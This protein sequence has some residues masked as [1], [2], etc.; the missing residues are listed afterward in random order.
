MTEET[1]QQSIGQRLQDARRKKELSRESVAGELNLNVRSIEALEN[2]NFD[3]IS[4]PMFTRGY[5][6]AYAR[7]LGM[8]ADRLI[9]EYN[10]LAPPDPELTSAYQSVKE[11]ES[12]HPIIRWA[13]LAIVLVT[14]TLLVF[15]WYGPR[16]QNIQQAEQ[17]DI[18]GQGTVVAEAQQVQSNSPVITTV[19]DIQPTPKVVDDGGGSVTEE[20]DDA[21]TQPESPESEHAS[22]SPASEDSQQELSEATNLTLADSTVVQVQEVVTQADATNTS[23]EP[24]DTLSQPVPT[25]TASAIEALAPIGSAV[26]ATQ[27][28]T[29]V[30]ETHSSGLTDVETVFVESPGVESGVITAADSSAEYGEAGIVGDDLLEI[31]TDSESWVEVIDANGARLM[32]GMLES[33]QVRE[34][35]GTAPFQVFLGNTPGITMMMNGAAVEQPRYN[36]ITNTS[37]FSLQADGNIRP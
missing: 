4:P 27:T 9:E 20:A 18:E 36:V 16:Y 28:P 5:L 15:W 13:T 14:G 26:A 23:S 30:V 12:S 2:D 11:T 29:T 7:L 10:E 1:Q 24:V 3:A 25:Q 22:L 35:Q 17:T 33:E 37:R 34:L 8:D 21:Q 6:R 31:R 32:Y 19:L